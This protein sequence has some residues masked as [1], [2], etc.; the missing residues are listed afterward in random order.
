MSANIQLQRLFSDGHRLGVVDH[1]LGTRGLDLERE[2][3]HELTRALDQ[4]FGLGPLGPVERTHARGECLL[5]EA[6]GLAVS[7]QLERDDTEPAERARIR[8]QLVGTRE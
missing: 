4:T 8:E 7:P 2:L 3:T 1:E 5:A 6:D